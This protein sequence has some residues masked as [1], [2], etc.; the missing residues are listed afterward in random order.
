MGNIVGCQRSY[1]LGLCLDLFCQNTFACK[2]LQYC[3]EPRTHAGASQ[4]M[5]REWAL[6]VVHLFTNPFDRAVL[7]METR[8]T[9]T[10]LDEGGSLAVRRGAE[11]RT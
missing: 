6:Y 11:S 1:F 7:S 9:R 8:S 5:W 4:G 2:S 10:T 3:D